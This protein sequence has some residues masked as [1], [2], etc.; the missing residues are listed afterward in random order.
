MQQSEK[1]KLIDSSALS[2][3]PRPQRRRAAAVAADLASKLHFAVLV[4]LLKQKGLRIVEEGVAGHKTAPF[5][6][7]MLLPKVSEEGTWNFGWLDGVKRF[8]IVLSL[9]SDLP[10]EPEWTFIRNRSQTREEK[11]LQSEMARYS[12]TSYGLRENLEQDPQRSAA[13]KRKA[14]LD[15]QV[16]HIVAC[17]QICRQPA[18]IITMYM[19]ESEEGGLFKLGRLSA[20]ED[21]QRL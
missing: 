18:G 3:V 17:L 1:S 12:S 20:T 9:P 7:S 21:A 13:S 8:V 11:D 14:S 4:K 5:L 16:E 6:G 19:A 15:A 2:N 10:D